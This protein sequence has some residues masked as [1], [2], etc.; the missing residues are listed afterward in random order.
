MLPAAMTC[1][2]QVWNIAVINSVVV[3]LPLVPVMA[4]TGQRQN[5]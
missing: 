5:R 1:L 2:S 4:T 3:V